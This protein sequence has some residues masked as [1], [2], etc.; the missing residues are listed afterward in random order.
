ML[1]LLDTLSLQLPE[2]VHVKMGLEIMRLKT[3][4]FMFPK[5]TQFYFLPEDNLVK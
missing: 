5:G 2:L 3:V 4:V 1:K